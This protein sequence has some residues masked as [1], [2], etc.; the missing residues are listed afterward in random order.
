MRIHLQEQVIR[1]LEHS[2]RWVAVVMRW[3]CITGGQAAVIRGGRAHTIHA[4]G[5]NPWHPDENRSAYPRVQP[6]PP[7]PFGGP[8]PTVTIRVCPFRSR[9]AASRRIGVCVDAERR[10]E[11]HT[12][13]A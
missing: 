9:N 5:P 1:A 13:H 7:D 6:G 11:R 8:R 3:R 10:I 12:G 4:C 2:R